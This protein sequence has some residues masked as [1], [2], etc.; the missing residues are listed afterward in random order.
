MSQAPVRLFSGARTRETRGARGRAALTALLMAASVWVIFGESVRFGFV[1]YDDDEFIGCNPLVTAEIEHP[2]LSAFTQFSAAYYAPTLWLAYRGVYRSFGLDPAAFHALNVLLHSL[3]VVLVWLLLRR[4]RAG[5]AAVPAA[6]L[7][8]L[9]PLRV[10][11]VAWVTELKDVLSGFFCLLSAIFILDAWRDASPGP[12]EGQRD[13]PSYYRNVLRRPKFFLALA[14]FF[15]GLGAKATVVI[16]PVSVLVMLFFLPE[17]A[18]PPGEAGQQGR[19]GTDQPLRRAAQRIRRLAMPQLPFLA[20]SCVFAWLHVRAQMTQEII[21]G[22]ILS[23]PAKVL[24]VPCAS[25]FFHFWKLIVPTDLCAFYTEPMP[26]S[27]TTPAY[28]IGIAA[29]LAALTVVVYSRRRSPWLCFGLVFFLV[30]MLPMMQ[31]IPTVFPFADR[32]T[33]LPSIGLF[34]ALVVLCMTRMRDSAG[35]GVGV[36]LAGLLALL[37]IGETALTMRRLPV[38][39]DS[40]SLW[41]DVNRWHDPFAKRNRLNAIW[42]TE[43]EKGM[44]PINPLQALANAYS[45]AKCYNEAEPL[46]LQALSIQ[47][48]YRKTYSNLTEMYVQTGRLDRAEEIV[49]AALQRWPDDTM[50]IAVLMRLKILQERPDEA[51]KLLPEALK[52]T[53]W[54]P[55][56]FEGVGKMFLATGKPGAAAECFRYCIAGAPRDG[57]FWFLY[58]CALIDEG[59]RAGAAEAFNRSLTLKP[60]HKGAMEA[61]RSLNEAGGGR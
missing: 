37:L 10:E 24:L 41:S 43:A 56:F 40:I 9:H 6:L 51:E 36:L 14:L 13:N 7:W 16:W 22:D 17:L 5:A 30:T 52:T 61:L 57:E 3:N 60:G 4:L 26:I 33:Y 49:R 23:T 48:T 45:Q 46:F 1:D 2:V 35:S 38:W 25:V 42:K 34:A 27:P 11:S 15:L 8:G 28:I 29:T 47:P 18:P 39:R 50:M 59:N 12:G 58:G 19:D 20:L 32:Y 55:M 53:E 54:R 31:F 44:I 21:R